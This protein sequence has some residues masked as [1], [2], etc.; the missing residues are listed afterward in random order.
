MTLSMATVVSHIRDLIAEITEFQRV[1]AAS[2]TGD[3]GIPM[4]LRQFPCA[5]VFPGPDVG[6]GYILSGGQHRHTY[7]VK[8]HI[9]EAGALTAERAAAVLPMVDLVIEKFSGNVTLGNRANSCIYRRQSGLA[10]LD[11]FGGGEYTGYEV[12]LE[13]SE[14]A[15][16]T[17]AGGN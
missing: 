7:E 4:A 1:Y 12:V 16:A 2:E 15:T 14:Q 13:V 10:V 9:Y 11:S 6:N 5:V 17:P 8:V 3:N